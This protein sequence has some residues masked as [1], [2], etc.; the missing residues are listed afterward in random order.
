[1]D[2]ITRVLRRRILK[3]RLAVAVAKRDRIEAR[4]RALKL[5]ESK[6]VTRGVLDD[7]SAHAR[8]TRTAL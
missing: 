6:R 8:S 5:R 4:L 2:P 7:M 1:M 3:E